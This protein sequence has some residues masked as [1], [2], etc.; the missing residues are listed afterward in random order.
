MGDCANSDGSLVPRGAKARLLIL[1][2]LV[3]ASRECAWMALKNCIKI[4]IGRRP[5]FDERGLFLW[6]Y[7]LHLTGLRPIRKITCVGLRREGAGSQALMIM[8]AINFARSSGLTYMHTPFTIIH[9]ADRP[10][11]EWATAWETLFNFGAGEAVCEAERREVVSYCHN[12]TALHLCLGWSHRSDELA[13][14]FRAIIPEFR[15][16]YYLNK[17]PRTT[18]EMTVAVH[19]RRGDISG[20]NPSYFTSNETVFRT[21]TSVITLLE[22]HKLKYRIRVY[23]Q[24]SRSDFAELSLLDVEFFLDVDAIWTMKQLIEADVLVMAQGC[25]SYYAALISD[26]IKICEPRI[27][28]LSLPS[29]NWIPSLTDGSFDRAAFERQLSLLIQAKAVITSSF[30]GSDRQNVAE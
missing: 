17:S 3:V 9:H 2:F 23:S 24:G 8:N 22:A 26:G 19:I 7:V 1:R 15:R 25:F 27:G 28:P 6:Q 21:I 14:N 30:V 29:E 10:M 5:Y 11:V 12:F 13:Q 20:D 18:D 4:L 16:K